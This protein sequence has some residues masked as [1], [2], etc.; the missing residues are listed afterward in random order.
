MLRFET[1]KLNRTKTVYD[2]FREESFV[3][4]PV[5][6]IE[7]KVTHKESINIETG[8]NGRVNNYNGYTFEKDIQ[9]GDILTKGNDQ[10]RVV[11][12]D[13][14]PRLSSIILEVL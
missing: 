4:E 12:I 11:W 2:E 3:L 9:V 6:D 8:F 14:V 7:V 10:L 1:Y 13:P 5:R